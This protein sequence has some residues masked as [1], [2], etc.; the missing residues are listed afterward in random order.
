MATVNS[1]LAGYKGQVVEVYHH[2][3]YAPDNFTTL[4]D[5]E[6]TWFFNN[7][8]NTYAPAGMANRRPALP[9]QTTAVIQ[10]NVRGDVQAVVQSAMQ[11]APYVG[12]TMENN[13]DDEA[14]TGKVSIDVTCYELPSDREHRLN[15]WLVQDSVM[16]YQNGSGVI[17]HN[18]AMR[19][20]LTG[21][22]GETIKL[23]EGETSTQTFE[24]AIPESIV[25]RY[26]QYTMGTSANEVDD[27]VILAFPENM[28]IVAFVSDHSENALN[29][30]VWNVE[31][32]DITDVPSAMTGISQSGSA[33]AEVFDLQGRKVDGQVRQGLYITNGK[34][35]LKR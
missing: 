13:Y 24:Y 32:C 33:K 26:A 30:M 6:Y 31:E 8:G 5:S 28:R 22:W 2:A 20:S 25:G 21:T 18:H 29:C 27:K 15:V 4:E 12:I 14:R 11:V 1:V 16:R 9:S 17:N 10:S 23:A 35:I 3:G 34:T 7:G 19:M